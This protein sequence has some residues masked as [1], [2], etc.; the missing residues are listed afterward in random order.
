MNDQIANWWKA[1]ESTAPRIVAHF[2]EQDWDL[3]A[4]MEEHLGAIHPELMWEFGPAVKV[5]GHRLVITPEARH[6]LRPL[7]REILQ[8]APPIANW[9]FYEYRL[10][11][12]LS[13]ASQSVLGRTGRKLDGVH[14]AASLGHF[15]LIDLK[16]HFPPDNF[17]EHEAASVAFVATESLLGEE[18]LDRWIGAIEVEKGMGGEAVLPLEELSGV[19]KA[20]IGEINET[21]PQEPW[22]QAD[23]DNALWSAL[24]G[25]PQAADDYA[26][27]DD[28]IAAI[29]VMPMMLQ[30]AL[31]NILFDSQRYSRFGEWF[32]YLKI[33][34]SSGLEHSEFADR[35]EIEEAVNAALRPD[36]FGSVVGGGTGLRYSYIELALTD[37]EVAWRSMSM[38]LSDGRLPKRTW[39]LFHDADLAAQWYGLYDDTPEPPSTQ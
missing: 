37:V 21:L 36:G 8:R 22:H 27:Q 20:L 6:D 12:G 4:W 16:Y 15:N 34:G 23:L 31:S 1:F 33:D 13:D 3:P 29:T 11:E 28:L 35:S 18:M 25:E 2:R 32:C 5:N 9:E 10:A 39:L 19:V 26:Q 7:V 38:V 30:N 17:D 14:V 24:E